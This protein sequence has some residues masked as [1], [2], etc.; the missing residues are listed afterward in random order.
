[1]G[2]TMNHETPRT[3]ITRWG[4]EL[5]PEHVLPEY[6]RPQM[7]RGN[8]QCLNGLFSGGAAFRC[9][10]PGAAGRMAALPQNLS[11]G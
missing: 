4:N 6:P 3:L 7:I 5:D 11:A 9:E 8:W 1:M 2:K 10:P